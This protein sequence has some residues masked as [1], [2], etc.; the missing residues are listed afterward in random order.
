MD[1][2]EFAEVVKKEFKEEDLFLEFDQDTP[3]RQLDGWSSIHALLLIALVDINFGVVLSGEDL[4]KCETLRA[5]FDLVK[6]KT[7]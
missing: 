5:V 6:Q 1:L 4:S 7:S 3:I 2:N